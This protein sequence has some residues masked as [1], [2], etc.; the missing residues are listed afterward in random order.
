MAGFPVGYRTITVD[1]L[2]ALIA[3]AKATL[4]F[5]FTGNDGDER[6]IDN[7]VYGKWDS[8]VYSSTYINDIKDWLLDEDRC[9]T[10]Y[11]QLLM[12]RQQH[13]RH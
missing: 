4:T 5:R 7:C 12:L 13:Q 8:S 2:A 6:T 3:F 1:L 9:V 11:A 10:Q